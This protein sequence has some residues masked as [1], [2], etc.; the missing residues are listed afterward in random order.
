M[1]L[2]PGSPAIGKGVAV[3]GVTADQR[4]FPLD[5]PIDIGAFQTK[6]STGKLVVNSTADGSGN[7][8]GKLDLR[9]A[10]DLADVLTG[11]QTITFDPTVFATAQ[12]IVLTAGPLDLSGTGGHRRSRAPRRG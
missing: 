7:Q 3:G 12:T 11:A 10:V 9:G 8:P 5:N 1:A 6:V 4:G 2:L